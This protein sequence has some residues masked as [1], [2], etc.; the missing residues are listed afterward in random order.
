MTMRKVILSGLL[1]ALAIPVGSALADESRP[2]T[3]SVTGRAR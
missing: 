1:A 3:V 2:R